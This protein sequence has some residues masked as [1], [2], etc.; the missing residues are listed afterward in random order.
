MAE[1]TNDFTW[2]KSR[3]EKFKECLRAYY[4]HYYGSWGGWGAREGAPERELW[5]LKRLSTRWQWA[6]SV[7][8]EAIEKLLLRAKAGAGVRGAD[9]LVEQTRRKAR[10]QWTA[11]R[12]KGY[13]R[14]PKDVLG[15]VEHEYAEPVPPE[16]WKRLWDEV[17]EASLRNFLAGPTFAAI[18]E[19]PRER[20]LTVDELD[21]FVF[22][23]TKIWVAVDFAYRDDRGRVHILDWKT[24][25]GREVDGTQVGIYALYAQEKWGVGPEDVVGGLVYLADGGERVDVPVDAPALDGCRAAMRESIAA[26]QGLLDDVPGNRASAARF[27][28]PEE[29]E[30]CRRCPF[31]RPCGRM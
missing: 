22:E 5:I 19:V 17:V 7:V 14:A 10:A 13:W 24:G 1:L 2:S 11:S 16:E 6:G 18:R 21:S 15:L 3:H 27:P 8:H 28:Q 30:C 9:E 26:M 4:L 12:E 29:R 31:R 23:G 25:R 20:W